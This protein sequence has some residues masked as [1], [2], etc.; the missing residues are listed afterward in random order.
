MTAGEAVALQP[1]RLRVVTAG[2]SDTVASLSARME[3]DERREELFRLINALGPTGQV[4]SG[5]RVKLI[6]Q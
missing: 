4:A 1:L 2:A 6:T 3:G 5:M